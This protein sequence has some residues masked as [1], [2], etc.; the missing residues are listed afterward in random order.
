MLFAN[1]VKALCKTE[2]FL[3]FSVIFRFRK[4]LEKNHR[5]LSSDLAKIR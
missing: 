1:A 5:H 3:V 2:I 4:E